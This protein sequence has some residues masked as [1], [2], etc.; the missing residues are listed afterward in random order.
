LTENYEK[1]DKLVVNLM[2]TTLK[3]MF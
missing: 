3:V 2:L 1:T